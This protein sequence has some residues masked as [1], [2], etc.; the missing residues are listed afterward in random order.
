MENVIPHFIDMSQTL[1]EV[2]GSMLNY[3]DHLQMKD[4]DYSVCRSFDCRR[5]MSKKNTMSYW[6]FKSHLSFQQKL[7]RNQQQKKIARMK[8]I[9]QATRKEAQE[10]QAIIESIIENRP[11]VLEQ[12][13][14][15]IVIPTGLSEITPTAEDRV[16]RYIEHLTQIITE[17]SELS[18]ADEI[19]HDQHHDAHTKLL[20]VEQKFT[21]N[22]ALKRLSD[23]L[24]GMCKGGCCVAG[25]EHAYLS[26]FTIRTMM[27]ENPHL[28]STH[29]LDLYLS[30]ISPQ[31]VHNACINQTATGC[32]LPK[33]LRSDICNAFYCDSL[34]S[35]QKNMA[36]EYDIGTV[37]AIQRS[38]TYSSFF[39]PDANNK[40]EN[41][42]V[43]CD[44]QK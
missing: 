20:Q 39:D 8:R 38:S 34:K 44:K 40:I 41:V 28:S 11:E 25:K 4:V 18:D 43:I 22:P 17:A 37:I 16:N 26:V 35:C 30:H 36:T 2:C 33:E 9:G 32:A 5:I 3:L 27:D 12:I 21:R 23:Q 13:K 29:I 6:Q 1:C 15:L 19:I 24:C 10:N 31:S 42:T 14:Q 7:Q